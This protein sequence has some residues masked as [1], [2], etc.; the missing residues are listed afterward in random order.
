M[1]SFEILLE[2]PKYKIGIYKITNTLTGRCYIGS[3][4]TIKDRL[5]N[6]YRELTANRHKNSKFQRAWNKYGKEVFKFEVLE[7]LK[8]PSNYDKNTVNQHLECREMFYID[9]YP[10]S[11][12]Y[13]LRTVERGRLGHKMPASQIENQKLYNSPRLREMAKYSQPLAAQARIGSSH[14]DESLIKMS[15]AK[16]NSPYIR[17]IDFYD[18]DGNYIKSF[19][20]YREASEFTKTKRSTIKN[21]LYGLSKKTK[22]GIFKFS[23]IHE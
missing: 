10:K 9:S 4:I 19:I 5:K 6:H 1:A 2:D 13:N 16:R 15:K 20:S 22:Q 18:L 21:N 11:K 3:S 17:Y 14:T 12:L 23:L 7:Y 8:F